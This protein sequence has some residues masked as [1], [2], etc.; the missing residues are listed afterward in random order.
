[1]RTHIV[2]ILLCV[3]TYYILIWHIIPCLLLSLHIYPIHIHIP[4]IRYIPALVSPFPRIRQHPSASVSIRSCRSIYTL[5]TYIFHI[6]LILLLLCLP[7][8]QHLVLPF[9]LL[10]LHLLH[11]PPL[12]LCQY[13]YFCTI[14]ASKLST[15]S[16]SSTSSALA[17][18]ASLVE[19]YLLY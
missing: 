5:Y 7:F 4:Y 14:K 11:F 6:Y 13:L 18:L 8:L 12:L 16:F 19:K 1:M 2:L 10:F 17:F 3:S 9:F 15:S